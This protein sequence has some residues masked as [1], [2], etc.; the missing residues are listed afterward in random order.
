MTPEDEECR[1]VYAHFGLAAYHAQCLE[2]DLVVSLLACARLAKTAPAPAGLDELRE[3]LHKRPLGTLL[4]EFRG[5]GTLDPPLEQLVE[6]ALKKRN[7][8]MH[9][10]FWERATDFLS[11]KGR[12]RMIGELDEIRDLLAKA[13]LVPIALRGAA[14]KAL[15]IPESRREQELD[16]MLKEAQAEDEPA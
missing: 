4:K 8:L 7:F 10:Y 13:S 14:L 12:A 6:D 3:S 5:L 16:K 11:A 2:K 9:H 15:G 1:E